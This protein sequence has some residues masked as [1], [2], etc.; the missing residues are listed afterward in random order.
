MFHRFCHIYFG[1]LNLEQIPGVSSVS[2]KI[3]FFLLGPFVG[4]TVPLWLQ[5][6][7]WAESPS[8][9]EREMQ[10]LEAWQ[11]V[12]Q[13]QQF[14]KKSLRKIQ[15]RCVSD[16]PRGQKE[17]A[18]RVWSASTKHFM[19]GES[20]NWTKEAN[21]RWKPSLDKALLAA[22][23]DTLRSPQTCHSVLVNSRLLL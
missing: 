12:Q 13:Q 1:Y 20:I 2:L 4:F 22:P 6:H 5:H 17:K 3:S 23:L 19:D 8:C 10:M 18:G 16:L 14:G 7:P 15:E 21:T 11:M 9:W